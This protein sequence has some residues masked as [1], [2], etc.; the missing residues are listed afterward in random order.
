[1]RLAEKRASSAFKLLQIRQSAA[2]IASQPD[3]VEFKIPEAEKE[4]ISLAG[5]AGRLALPSPA[6]KPGVRLV[7][8]FPDFTEFDRRLDNFKRAAHAAAALNVS[9]AP[10]IGFGES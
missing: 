2:D 10:A 7:A 6:G 4:A 3:N 9:G 8:N 1:V 5:A